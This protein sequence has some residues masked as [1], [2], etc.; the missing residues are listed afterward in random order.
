MSLVDC[1]LVL[2]GGVASGLVHAGAVPEL[3]RR[4]RFAGVAGSSA[5]AIAAAFTAAAEYARAK[6]DAD[7]FARLGQRSAELPSQLLGLFQPSPGLE[8]PARA[9][10]HLA[11]GTGRARVISAILCFW[12]AL[13]AGF[14]AGAAASVL[15]DGRADFV[16]RLVGGLVLGICG[17][18]AGLVLEA[19]TVLRRVKR[20]N[21]GICSGLSQGS[22]PAL[23]D[24]LH[25]SLQDIAF[26]PG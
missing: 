20:L 10:I 17:A 7:G 19:A 3:A 26:G 15:L 18:A 24:W 22:R 9:L 14:L 23:T 16:F 13:L 5:G 2:K 4:Y 6:G 8:R 11:P 21:F 25:A 1:N 12:P